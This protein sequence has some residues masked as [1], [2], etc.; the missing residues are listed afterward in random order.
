MQSKDREIQ[1]LKDQME[2]MFDK[3]KKQEE[4]QLRIIE[5]LNNPK[6]VTHIHGHKTFLRPQMQLTMMLITSNK[7]PKT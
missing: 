1:T 3:I 7:F 2:K 4:S 6:M 5:L